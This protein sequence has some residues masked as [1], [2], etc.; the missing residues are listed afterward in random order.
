MTLKPEN[1]VFVVAGGSHPTHAYW[2][3]GTG[4]RVHGRVIR[5]PE[6]FDRLLAQ[7]DRALGCGSEECRI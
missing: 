3:Q 5:T 7:A 4:P 1:I 6:T 2:L